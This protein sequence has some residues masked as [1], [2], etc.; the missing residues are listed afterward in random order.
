MGIFQDL[1]A[2]F[3]PKEESAHFPQLPFVDLSELDILSAPN[4]EDFYPAFSKH[5]GESGAVRLLLK[6]DPTGRVVQVKILR[7]SSFTRLDQAAASLSSQFIFSPY[8]RDGQACVMQTSV[9]VEFKK[10]T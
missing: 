3:V 10:T 4:P 9:E 2:Y 5:A 8:K 7:S 6:V 1:F